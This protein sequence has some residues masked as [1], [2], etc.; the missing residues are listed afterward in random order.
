MTKTY[1]V[2]G[3]AGFIGSNF[4][5]YLLWR[6]DDVTVVNVDALTYAGNLENIADLAG[7]ER[8]VFV[9]ADICDQ[10][11]LDAVFGKY[12]PDYVVNFAAQSHVDRAIE[13][14]YAFNQANAQGILS[15]M[16]AA[17]RDWE[18]PDGSFGNH[19]F[20]QVSSDEVY[21]SR[22]AATCAP[23]NED[24]LLAPGNP[25]SASKAAAE[26]YAMA[27]ANTYGF[28]VMIVRCCNNYG[29]YQHPEKLIPKAI[30]NTLAGQEVCLY[31]DGNNMRDWIYVADTCRAIDMIV[32]NA[33][34]GQIYNVSANCERS[35]IDVISALA[36]ELDHQTG[37]I[38][39]N[40]CYVQDRPGHDMRYGINASKLKRELGW[41][42]MTSFEEGL[43]KTVYWYLAN[44]DWT[45]RILQGEVKENNMRLLEEWDASKAAA[46][47]QA[48]KDE[49]KAA[50]AAKRQNRRKRH[51]PAQQE[52]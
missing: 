1:L 19:V 32:N 24:S 10:A 15:L 42:P 43:R 44:E 40:V 20:L 50:K 6:Y 8:H 27:F 41:K 29:P 36:D 30:A 11:A 46:K 35:N 28:P 21:G 7:D 3:G 52:Q 9:H 47:K 5:H 31:G 23:F 12:G 14:P 34:P 4:V 25:Y 33:A 16:D 48:R 13:D 26:H 49:Q 51:R 2:T 22:D 37:G 45:T 38:D 18:E 39:C 17:G